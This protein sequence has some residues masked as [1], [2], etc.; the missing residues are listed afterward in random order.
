MEKQWLLIH[1]QVT[2]HNTV[3]TGQSVGILYL[4]ELQCVLYVHLDSPM[5]PLWLKCMTTNSV[6]IK[7]KSVILSTRSVMQLVRRLFSWLPWDLLH[8]NI[9]VCCDKKYIVE[10]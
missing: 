4:K 8:I 6:L 3:C 1:V 2:K 9:A 10:C 5:V 7:L